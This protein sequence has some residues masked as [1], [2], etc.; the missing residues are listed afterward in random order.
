MAK[1]DRA[2]TTLNANE[3]SVLTYITDIVIDKDNNHLDF[4]AW[5]GSNLEVVFDGDT[6]K[7]DLGLGLPSIK[8][9]LGV[10]NKKSFITQNE[11]LIT[12]TEENF[13]A[14]QGLL[15]SQ[16]VKEEA[17][18]EVKKPV[19]EAP[20]KK[21]EKKA[22]AKVKVEKA[23]KVEQP[24]GTYTP[25]KIAELY[26]WD[27]KKIRKKIR[28]KAEELKLV[29]AGDNWYLTKDQVKAVFGDIL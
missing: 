28:A 20:V 6:F 23:K 8:K 14:I 5:R 15:K 4:E 13:K 19:G 7:N 18:V 16:P 3:Q 27:G 22:P 9:I 21:E 11:D 12:I 17:P 24:E 25:A 10:L 29:K 26:G 2:M 1:G